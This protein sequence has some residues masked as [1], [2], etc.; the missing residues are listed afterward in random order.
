MTPSPE[1]AGVQIA[2]IGHGKVPF[3]VA[4]VRLEAFWCCR[5]NVL[6]VVFLR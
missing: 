1:D 2:S 6:G 3:S 4:V 5:T